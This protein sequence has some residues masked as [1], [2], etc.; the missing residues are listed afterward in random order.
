[1]AK[2]T[3]KDVLHVANLARL[4]LSDGEV[5]KF[6]DQLGDII[7]FIGQLQEVDVKNVEPTNQTTGLE[8]VYRDDEIKIENSLDGDQALSG[9][10]K[11]H[12]GYFVVD[13]LLAER[14]DK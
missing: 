13:A 4:N 6:T 10:D 2:L 5:N 14:S 8:N 3:K 12:N 7:E 11:T 1:M 9:T